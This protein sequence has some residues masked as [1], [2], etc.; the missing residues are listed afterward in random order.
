MILITK[1]YWCGMA[2]HTGTEMPSFWWNSSQWCHNEHDGISNYRCLDCLLNCLFRRRSKETSKLRITGLCEG[3]SP[4]TG[5][6][7][8]QRASNHVLSLVAPTVVKM[9]TSG[10]ASDDNFIKMVTF[11]FH[12]VKF[13]QQEKWL[14]QYL[15]INILDILIPKHMTVIDEAIYTTYISS[16]NYFIFIFLALTINFSDKDFK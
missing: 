16:L 2:R 7:P 12:C 8:T 3:N 14:N 11:P 15:C 10:W 13:H 9:A 6:F 5:E 4:V 1:G